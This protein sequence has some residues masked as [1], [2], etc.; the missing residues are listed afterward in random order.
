MCMDFIRQMGLNKKS[1]VDATL[2][3]VENV[4]YYF[5]KSSFCRISFATKR[6]IENNEWKMT[7]ILLLLY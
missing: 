7:P 2:I 1:C 5:E 3:C 6:K 4:A